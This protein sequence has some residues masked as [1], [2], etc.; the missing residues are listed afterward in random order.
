MSSLPFSD[1]ESI[2]RRWVQ[3]TLLKASLGAVVDCKAQPACAGLLSRWWP[4]NPE[5]SP[6]KKLTI[7]DW[8][9]APAVLRGK[10]IQRNSAV[11]LR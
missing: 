5:V 4:L 3:S 9:S 7:P 6:L 8:S 11:A 2:E 10:L 1:V